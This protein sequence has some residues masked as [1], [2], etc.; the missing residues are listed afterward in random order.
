[1]IRVQIS[2]SLS[3]S[4]FPS[5]PLLFVR[6]T[7]QKKTTTKT[8][9]LKNSEEKVREKKRKKKTK[10]NLFF[11]TTHR[12]K[13][14]N[15]SYTY[16]QNTRHFSIIPSFQFD[17][18]FFYSIYIYVYIECV[19]RLFFLLLLSFYTRNNIYNLIYFINHVLSHSFISIV[20]DK[21]KPPLFFLFFFAI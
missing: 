20:N 15:I 7:S 14:L 6:Q 4:C 21:L 1:M 3:L 10:L 13:Q 2:K 9:R 16:I 5:S 18:N 17:K 8:P 11:N 12:F 19:R